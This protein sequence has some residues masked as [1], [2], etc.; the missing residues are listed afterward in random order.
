[1]N[2]KRHLP[3]LLATEPARGHRALRRLC[4]GFALVALL[5]S[6]LLGGWQ[7]LERNY[8]SAWDGRGYDLPAWV[9]RHLPGGEA[10]A[11]AYDF[12]QLLGGG[13]ANSFFS[14]PFIDPVLAPLA[15]LTSHWTP[16]IVLGTLLPMVLGL[17]AGRAFC[18]WFCPFGTLARLL[19]SGLRRLPFRPKPLRVPS[20]R[21]LRYAVLVSLFALSFSAS[22]HLQYWLLPHLLMQQS[23]YAFWLLGGGGA[24]FAWFCG[25][26]V[27][28]LAFGPTMYC[29]T[30]CP[31]GAFLSVLARAKRVHVTIEEAKSCG[32]HCHLCAQACWLSLRPDLG[33]PGPDC[34]SC[35]RCFEVCPRANLRVGILSPTSPHQA[36]NAHR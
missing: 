17:L 4:Q 34:D 26:I 33:D 35:A 15:L 25:L 9:L 2:E 24:V 21:W 20:R 18:G 8:L 23:A 13:V 27:A 7:R 3:L 6:P 31:T 14:L 36:T 5:F 19:E 32:T 10:A 29:A 22:L 12:N 16:W 28:G 1:M 11:M 30:L